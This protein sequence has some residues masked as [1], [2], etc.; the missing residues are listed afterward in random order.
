MAVPSQIFGNQDF[1]CAALP[2]SK[3]NCA[4]KTPLEKNGPGKRPAA[5][6]FKDHGAVRSGRSAAAKLV[7]HRHAKPTDAGGLFIQLRKMGDFLLIPF[8]NDM[9]RRFGLQKIPRHFLHHI[10]IVV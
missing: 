6:F 8:S 5:K 2:P 4:A 10:L 1:C 3:N 7:G 9:R